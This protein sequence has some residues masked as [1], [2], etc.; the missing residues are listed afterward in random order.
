MKSRWLS[1]FTLIGLL[2]LVLG[3]AGLI[4]Q[5]AGTGMVFDP[6][7]PPPADGHDRTAWYYLV[8][9]ALM[10]LNGLVTPAPAPGEM[11]P[12]Q[13]KGAARPDAPA[14]I[15]TARPAAGREV[16]ATSADKPGE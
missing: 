10:V 11:V 15:S 7:Q 9:G 14:S 5:H 2:L 8:I 3:V 12:P 6:G 16:I 4:L 13:K 1:T